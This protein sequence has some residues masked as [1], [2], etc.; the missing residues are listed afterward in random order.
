MALVNENFLS[1]HGSYLFSKISR[2]VK[3]FNILNPEAKLISMGIGDVTRPLVEAVTDAMHQAVNEMSYAETFRGYGPDQGYQFLIDKIIQNDFEPR[4]V[5]VDPDEVFISD[6]CKSDMGNIGGILSGENIVAVTD[7]VYPVYIDTNVMDGRAGKLTGQDGWSNVVYLP[8]TAENGFIPDL[9]EKPVDIL[10]LCFPN[11]PTGTTLTKAEL[12]KWVDFALETGALILFDAAYE[13]FISEEDVPHSIY[14]I[15][16]AES[17][18]IEFRSFSKTA[19]FTGIRCGYTI[20]PKWVTAGSVS[21]GK[22]ALNTLWN[23]RQTTKFNGVSYVT[24]KAAEAVY[25]PEGKVQCAVNIAYYMK[26]AEIIRNCLTNKGLQV[27]GGINAPYVWFKTPENSGSW[28]FFDR[29]LNEINVIGTPGVGFGP[30][31]EGYVRLTAFGSREDTLTAMKRFESW[32][33]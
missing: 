26:N 11:N 19:G 23:R 21:Q 10:Y 30:S 17:C 8:C 5:E 33:L 31:G 13:T 16:G 20:V 22:V 32:G 7:P 18:A 9:P 24:Q 1:L 14:E 28:K 3:F 6:G 12:K 4:G 29:M 25:S 15:E 2:K 27:F